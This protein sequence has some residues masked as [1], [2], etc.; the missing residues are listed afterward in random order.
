MSGGKFLQ[1]NHWKSKS[2]VTKYIQQK[3]ELWAKTMAILFLNYFENCLTALR[4]YL[5][6]LDATG[7]YMHSFLHSLEMVMP[8]VA[9][10]DTGKLV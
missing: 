6:V 7:V 10:A 9:I 8:N 3:L 5:P 4:R 1:I 2:L